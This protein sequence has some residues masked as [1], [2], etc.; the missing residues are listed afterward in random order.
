MGRKRKGKVQ[1]DLDFSSIIRQHI[2]LLPPELAREEELN[3]LFEAAVNYTHKTPQQREENRRNKARWL[4]ELDRTSRDLDG[5]TY[6]EMDATIKAVETLLPLRTGELK[7]WNGRNL[8]MY[9]AAVDNRQNVAQLRKNLALFRKTLLSLGRRSHPDDR[10]VSPA[11]GAENEKLVQFFQE[12]SM[13]ES[14]W[15]VSE[16]IEM[17]QHALFDDARQLDSFLQRPGLQNIKYKS[18]SDPRQLVQGWKKLIGFS[19]GKIKYRASDRDR[20]SRIESLEHVLITCYHKP[21]PNKKEINEQV[22]WKPNDAGWG[23]GWGK[24]GS[25]LSCHQGLRAVGY[26]IYNGR[27]TMKLSV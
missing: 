27:T 16:V 12:K 14:I 19:N 26:H 6:S 22:P 24:R 11:E 15:A 1:G 8:G 17:D 2:R 21:Q 7:I 23:G 18:P 9:R 3:T 4:A 10:R 25:K 5:E 13:E 20:D